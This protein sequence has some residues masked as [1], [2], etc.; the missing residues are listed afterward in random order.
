[1]NPKRTKQMPRTRERKPVNREL[2]S[3]MIKMSN[4]SQMTNEMANI[5]SNSLSGEELIKMKK[6]L[7]HANYQIDIKYNGE[8]K[9]RFDRQIKFI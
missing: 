8:K 3:G 2:L 6:W 4:N 1:M 7:N 9:Y 5:L